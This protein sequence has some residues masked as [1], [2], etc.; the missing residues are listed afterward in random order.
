VIALWVPFFAFSGGPEHA[1][2]A[3]RDGDSF[4]VGESDTVGTTIIIGMAG[5]DDYSSDS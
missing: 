5:N 4:A 3:V 2:V 1:V